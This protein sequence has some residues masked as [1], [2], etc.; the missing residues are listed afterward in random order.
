MVIGEFEVV[1]LV[2]ACA[3]GPIVCV[4]V[5]RVFV[6]QL[7]QQQL[8]YAFSIQIDDV[9]LVHGFRDLISEPH[10]RHALSDYMFL[11][12]LSIEKKG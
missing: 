11:K 5:F 10:V 2:Y 6:I 3:I 1:C 7:Q 9:V 12:D 4:L 8:P